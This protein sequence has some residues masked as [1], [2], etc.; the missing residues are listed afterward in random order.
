M[1]KRLI[2]LGAAVLVIAAAVGFW[3]RMDIQEGAAVT[4]LYPDEDLR[5]LYL[6]LDAE[7][8]EAIRTMLDGCLLLP[9]WTD[10]FSGQRFFYSPAYACRGLLFEWDGSSVL[11]VLPKQGSPHL[12]QVLGRNNNELIWLDSADLDALAA[13]FEANGVF[14]PPMLKE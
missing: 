6:T 1:K 12:L 7:D 11:L 13:I 9:D 3:P 5:Q 10:I 2:V 14:C 8:G 4:L